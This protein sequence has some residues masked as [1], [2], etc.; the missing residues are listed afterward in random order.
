MLIT[1]HDE[2]LTGAR[3]ANVLLFALTLLGLG[4]ALAF[5]VVT[6]S[7]DAL[8]LASDENRTLARFPGASWASVES[9][10][11][12]R[13]V[14]EWIA[15]HFPARERLLELHFWLDQH[16][17]LPRD[18]EDVSVYAV[19]IDLDADLEPLADDARAL[20]ELDRLVAA[21]PAAD[22]G[23]LDDAGD[24]ELLD[25][26][27]LDEASPR[28]G[29]GGEPTR[30]EG[31]LVHEGRAMQLFAGGPKGSRHYAA[32]LNAY[33]ERVPPHVRI[34][35]IIVPTAQTYYMPDNYEGRVREEPPNIS[36]TYDMLD[37][38]IA[39]VDV[40]AALRGH[41]HEPIYFRT[42]H[43]WTG[44]AAY[45]AYAAFCTVAGLEP[46]ALD[47][48]ASHTTGPFRGSLYSYTRDEKLRG[49]PDQVEYFVPPGEI[50]VERYLSVTQKRPYPGTLLAEDSKTYG[51]FL[52]G[53]HP[54]MV[55]RTPLRTGR[56]ALLV[57]NSYGNPFGVLLAA[58]FDEVVIVD[59]RKFDGSILSM[60]DAHD[61]TD[62]IF[63][64]GAIT[65]NARFHIARLVRIMLGGDTK[66]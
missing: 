46:L 64:N 37:E 39:T 57:K 27:P 9:G 2:L 8:E 33:A 31:I 59:Y 17:G 29:K 65:A 38:R 60:I 47:A 54:I 25:D 62:L 18:P 63:I 32:A 43:H 41:E 42:D 4:G 5:G 19:E 1:E 52:G 61:I 45:Y 40:V 21:T 12:A 56:R 35:S 26:A 55:V 23:E 30:S 66:G 22:A 16:R 20:A 6:R 14:D 50:V 53:D 7:D 44:R 34:Y 51:V 58:S 36:A 13:G 10:A 24:L 48:L 3:V 15:D 28:R 49:K 11:Y